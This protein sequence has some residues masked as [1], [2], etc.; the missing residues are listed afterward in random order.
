MFTAYSVTVPVLL[1]FYTPLT[2]S[3][4]ALQSRAG[5]QSHSEH[6]HNKVFRL[7]LRALSFISSRPPSIPPSV[8]PCQKFSLSCSATLCAMAARDTT[9]EHVIQD[10]EANE[11][12]TNTPPED[13][14]SEYNY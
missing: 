10:V 4:T 13:I 1:E 14:S 6:R 12:G 3:M 8:P 11:Q 5:H 2:G 9:E 7:K